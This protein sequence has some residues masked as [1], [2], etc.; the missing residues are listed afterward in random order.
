MQVVKDIR[1]LSG[2]HDVNWDIVEFEYGDIMR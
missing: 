2:C 1:F